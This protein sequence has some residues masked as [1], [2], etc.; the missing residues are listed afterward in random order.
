MDHLILIYLILDYYLISD[1]SHINDI[2]NSIDFHI[3][4]DVEYI[5]YN[6]IYIM[7]EI[8]LRCSR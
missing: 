8:I 2:I 6:I 7:S 5:S 1:L 4:I 3:H